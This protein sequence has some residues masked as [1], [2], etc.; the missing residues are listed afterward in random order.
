MQSNAWPL[1]C[2]NIKRPTKNTKYAAVAEIMPSHQWMTA[3]NVTP[4]WQRSF[5]LII[6][7]YINENWHAEAHKRP[8]H[9]PKR[10][11]RLCYK[12]RFIGWIFWWC[13]YDDVW[14]QCKRLH[15]TATTTEWWLC[16]SD[17]RSQMFIAYSIVCSSSSSSSTSFVDCFIQTENSDSLTS[18][19]R[20]STIWRYIY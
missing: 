1:L 5:G 3:L 11:C 8:R 10:I 4:N 6:R 9:H 2:Y 19:N 14:Q 16:M 12:F 18:P 7:L 17:W 15:S 13:T 20:T